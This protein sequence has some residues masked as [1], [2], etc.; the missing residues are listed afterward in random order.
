MRTGTCVPASS[1]VAVLLTVASPHKTLCCG[2]FLPRL[3]NQRS[4]TLVTGAVGTSGTSSSSVSPAA[5]SCSASCR[6][7]SWSSE[8]EDI[9]VEIRVLQGSQLFP[10]HLLVPAGMERE[11]VIGDDQ[12]AALDLR[13]V[14][15][16]NNRNFAHALTLGRPEARFTSDKPAVGRN[17]NWVYEAE[18]P[19]G[20]GDL[21]HLLRGMCAR[22]SVITNQ[23]IHGPA[24]DLDV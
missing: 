10:K 13:K 12:G 4:P 19:D 18:F 7:N 21:R 5:S 3:N 11:L 17:E 22:V 1:R 16:H 8:T 14:C 9:Q 23:S 2:C 24:L 20:G 15:Q 6:A